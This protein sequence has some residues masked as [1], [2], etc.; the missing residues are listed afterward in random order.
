MAGAVPADRALLSEA[1]E[2]PPADRG[3]ARTA[4]LFLTA[5]VQPVGSGGRRGDLRFAD[6]APLCRIDLGREPMSDE[7]TVCRFRHLLEAHNLGRR[8]FDEVQRHLEEKGLK[9]CHRHHCR[10]DDHQCAVFYQDAEKAR[11]PRCIRRRRATSG[12]SA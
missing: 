2:R 9:G 11:D 12:I 6:D 1:G 4:H 10:C 5:M 7:T 8:L 3:R